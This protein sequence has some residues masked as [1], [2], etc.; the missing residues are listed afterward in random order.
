MQQDR[1]GR[2]TFWRM[3][4]SP[5]E[6]FTNLRSECVVGSLAQNYRQ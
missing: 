3:M 2:L 5:E 6:N 4:Q 1:R